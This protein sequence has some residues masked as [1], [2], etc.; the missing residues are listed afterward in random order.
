MISEN[1]QQI[2]GL[3]KQVE[4]RLKELRMSFFKNYFN[5]E[6]D[7][8]IDRLN[9]NKVHDAKR[10]VSFD[11]LDN[12]LD[13]CQHGFCP[14]LD[15]KDQMFLIDISIR[16]YI[17]EKAKEYI[18][19]GEESNEKCGEEIA[20]Q[21]VKCI[22][23]CQVK[24][25]LVDELFK[26][27][28]EDLMKG[29]TAEGARRRKAYGRYLERVDKGRPL[30]PVQDYCDSAEFIDKVICGLEIERMTLDNCRIKWE[31]ALDVV[32]GVDMFR[33]CRVRELLNTTQKVD[34]KE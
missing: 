23:E 12:L 30:D 3:S 16:G 18:K 32:N 4:K 25:R 14:P 28:L 21:R 27:D 13:C 31:Q 24:P 9:G 11:V 34:A 7:R 1:R 6:V 29:E 20:E 10:V 26:K 22:F 2:E 17:K 33:F 19:E 15:Q 8:I 5:E